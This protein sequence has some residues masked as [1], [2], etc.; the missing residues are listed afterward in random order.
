MS[1]SKKLKVRVNG[2]KRVVIGPIAKSKGG[3]GRVHLLGSL[4]D[5]QE[6]V[7]ANKRLSN[8]VELQG[9]VAEAVRKSKVVG[10]VKDRLGLQVS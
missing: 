10:A 3:D 9:D 2:T 1:D 4:Q 8:S 6:A 5:Q 7:P